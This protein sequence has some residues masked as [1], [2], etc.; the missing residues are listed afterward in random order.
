MTSK[1]T[2]E[3]VGRKRKCD[4]CSTALH[5]KQQTAITSTDALQLLERRLCVSPQV[6]KRLK[7][8]LDDGK[9]R[10]PLRLLLCASRSASDAN[11]K[12]KPSESGRMSSPV[13]ALLQK[14]QPVSRGNVPS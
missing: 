12:T 1:E 2:S 13:R 11:V 6:Y 10:I 14:R 9:A 5:P 8:S 4:A 3:L 7:T